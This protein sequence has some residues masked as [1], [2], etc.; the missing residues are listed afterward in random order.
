MYSNLEFQ[1]SIRLYSEEV[2]GNSSY[3]ELGF[4][5]ARLHIFHSSVRHRK[6]RKI[7]S[8]AGDKWH[9]GCTLSAGAEDLANSICAIMSRHSGTYFSLHGEILAQS[10]LQARQ[11]AA[12]PALAR[13]SSSL[14]LVYLSQQQHIQST[15]NVRKV[16]GK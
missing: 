3:T 13:F 8:Q 5:Q 4:Q 2:V 7:H 9:T 12:C 10:H 11:C 6:V 15:K 1:T 16:S 14:C